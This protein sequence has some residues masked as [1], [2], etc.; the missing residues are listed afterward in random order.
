MLN[1]FRGVCVDTNKEAAANYFA[2]ELLM[3][4]AVLDTLGARSAEEIG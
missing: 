3:P 2:R 1:H 4:L